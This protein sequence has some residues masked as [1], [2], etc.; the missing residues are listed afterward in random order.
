MYF[1]RKQVVLKRPD[2]R[3]ICLN[4]ITSKP[5]SVSYTEPYLG[6][7]GDEPVLETT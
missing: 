1:L 3:Q 7:L 6:I 4:A 5:Q 2:G